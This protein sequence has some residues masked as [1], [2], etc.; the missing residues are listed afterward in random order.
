MTDCVR[1]LCLVEEV[2]EDLAYPREGDYGW[3]ILWL[4]GGRDWGNFLS[5]GW[6]EGREFSGWVKRGRGEG[7]NRDSV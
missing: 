7:V 1:D 6:E 2:E 5:G 3:G 4:R